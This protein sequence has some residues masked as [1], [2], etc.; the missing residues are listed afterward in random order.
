MADSQTVLKESFPSL[1]SSYSP[2]RNSSLTLNQEHFVA[3]MALC[4]AGSLAGT[5]EHG[6]VPVKKSMYL[7]QNLL[8][9]RKLQ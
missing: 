8:R 3:Q 2:V 9:Y 6:P 1:D 5:T 7:S 4:I